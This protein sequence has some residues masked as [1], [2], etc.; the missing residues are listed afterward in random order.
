MILSNMNPNIFTTIFAY[1][2]KM[3]TLKYQHFTGTEFASSVATMMNQRDSCGMV[4][5]YKKET[6]Y[7]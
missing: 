2:V 7:F 5:F 4:T 1:Y 3:A 6:S